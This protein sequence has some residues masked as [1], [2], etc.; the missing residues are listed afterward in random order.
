MKSNTYTIVAESDGGGGFNDV[1]LDRSNLG[2]TPSETNTSLQVSCTGLEGGLY[3]VYLK[4]KGSKSFVV[5]VEGASEFDA[6]IL[7]QKFLF[8]AVAIS[9]SD[10]GAG[11]TPTTTCTFINR[12]F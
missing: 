7:D 11:A 8:D 9:F 5:F 2:F 1:V 3:G 6:V 12:S 10:L 4:P